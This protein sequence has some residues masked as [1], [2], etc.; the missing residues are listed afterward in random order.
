MDL[1]SRY[2]GF[3]LPNPLISSAGPM[4]DTLDEVKRMEDAGIAMIVLRSIFQEQLAREELAMDIGLGQ[5]DNSSPEAASYLPR[6]VDFRVGPD[7]YLEHLA[8]VKTAVKV[9]IVASLN[10]VTVG[11]WTSF[12]AQLAQAGADA[13]ELNI[14]DPVLDLDTD[15]ATVEKETIEV[16]RAVRKA[17][18]I[19]LAVKLSPFYT[20]LPHIARQMEKA[21]ANALVLFNRF[22]QPDLD[23][24]KLAPRMDLHLSTSEELPLRLRWLAALWGR[25]DCDLAA[26]GGVHTGM[27][28]LKAVSAGAAGVQMTSALLKNGSKHIIT[29]RQAM[30]QWLEDHEYE[31][32][33]QLRGSMSLLRAPD[34]SAYER[35]NYMHLL[36]SWSP[37]M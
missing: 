27:D 16:I 22:Y 15:S 37:P 21:G 11:G 36:Q 9:P 23:L 20:G 29:M 12:A 31:N 35:G 10:G 7:E 13:L 17:V 26:T 32:L 33:A 1:K 18:K 14:Y 2:L 8:R 24:E 34:P 28:A 5:A 4:A 19:P 25:V 3:D 30:V 6:P